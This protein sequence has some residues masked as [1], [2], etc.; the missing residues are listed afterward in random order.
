MRS[1]YIWAIL[2][3]LGFIVF[4]S[5][6]SYNNSFVALDESVH[7]SW[8]KVQSAYQ[9]RADLIPNLVATVRGAADF[10]KETLEAVVNARA[11]ASSVTIDPSNATPAQIQQF[12]EAQNGLSQSLGRLLVVAERYPELKASASFQQLQAQLEGQENRIRVERNR[13][14]DSVTEYNTT[15]RRFPASFFASIFGFDRAAQFEAAQDAQN[16]PKVEF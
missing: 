12:Q 13:Y 2:L 6:C 9:E 1:I 15:I 11:K 10:E 8:S 3:G 7:N 5:A 4:V 14:N 16:A